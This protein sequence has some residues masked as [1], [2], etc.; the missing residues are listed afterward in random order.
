M[1]L[2]STEKM[3]FQMKPSSSCA[4]SSATPCTCPCAADSKVATLSNAGLLENVGGSTPSRTSVPK[5]EQCR[6]PAG[7][8]ARSDCM[9][10]AQTVQVQR[11]VGDQAL[12]F[13]T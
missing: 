4:W 5:G 2:W 13:E 12:T 1:T 7:D 10:K 11:P 6:Y 3:Y 8:V 9:Q